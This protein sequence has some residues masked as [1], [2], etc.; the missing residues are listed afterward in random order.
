M[1]VVPGLA[2]VNAIRDLIAGDLLSGNARLV[3]AVMIAI[4]LSVGAVSGPLLFGG[5]L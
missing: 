1:Q 2:L 3:E 4:G 5:F